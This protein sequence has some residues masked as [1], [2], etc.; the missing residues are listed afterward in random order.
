MKSRIRGKWTADR[1][2]QWVLLPFIALL[3]IKAG[4]SMLGPA[5]AAS[6]VHGVR[7]FWSAGK[8]VS[9]RRSGD[10]VG[11]FVSSDG[12]LTVHNVDYYGMTGPENPGSDIR[13]LYPG[14]GEAFPPGGVPNAWREPAVFI[15][16]GIV[17]LAWWAW[18]F[19]VRL[20]RHRNR[21]AQSLRGHT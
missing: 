9:G 21:L 13:A 17:F 11:T 20:W 10:W 12:K 1:L 3:A 4:I 18:A 6:G 16:A 19:P 14:G 5:I 7:G 8:Y 15:V 2:A